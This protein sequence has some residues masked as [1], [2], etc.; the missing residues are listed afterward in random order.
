MAM[1]DDSIL[2]EHSSVRSHGKVSMSIIGPNTGIAA[3]EVTASLVGPFIGFHH[4][5]LLIAALWPEG[6]GNVGYGANVGSNHTS[7]APDQEIQCGE[8][9]F[10]G[11]GTSI[12][13]PSDFT[14]A[15][16]SIIATGVTTLP[17]HMEFPFSLINTPSENVLNVPPAYNE[18]FPGWVL[19]EN[20]Y[21]LKRNEAKFKA[22]NKARRTVFN[23]DAVRPEIIDM[24]IVAR[25][26]LKGV[27][28]ENAF[29]TDSKI[30][31]LGK[32]LLT[33]K[34]RKRGIASYDMCIEYYCLRGLFRYV[35]DQFKK[36]KKIAFASAF[37]LATAD[38]LW[39]HQREI[40]VQE[41]FAALS[42]KENLTRLIY[43]EEQV[44]LN[45]HNAKGKDDVRGAKIFPDYG[46]IHPP[47]DQDACVKE[48]RLNAEKVKKEITIILKKLES[49]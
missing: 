27:K 32:N 35:T 28:N 19:Y 29:Y 18:I 4:Q 12:K 49:L 47:A 37:T 36:G 25:N 7:R 45:V 39:E 11:L 5:A 46:T 1:V 3:G 15:P 43:L 20:M 33:E 9:M 24:M 41:N 44:A 2:T 10:F 48:A 31:G 16:Y 34:S 21:A 23:T 13:F 30:P 22:R 17:Q 38:T 26:R 8:G 42:I 40:M 14:R 6:K